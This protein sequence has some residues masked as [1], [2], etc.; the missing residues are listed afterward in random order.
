MT[1]NHLSRLDPALIRP[2]RVDLKELISDATPHQASSLFVRFYSP[3]PSS[4]T[5][6]VVEEGTTT[7]TIED[8]TALTAE[9]VE[10]LRLDLVEQVRRFEKEGLR[11]SMA[12]LQGHFIRNDGRAAVAGF[13]ELVRMAKE[14]ERARVVFASSA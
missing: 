9:E 10:T 5:T 8:P 1:T 2:G 7:T 14:D 6:P 4:S 3:S 13:E 11:V 12:G